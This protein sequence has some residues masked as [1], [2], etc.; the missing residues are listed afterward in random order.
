MAEGAGAAPVPG[1][2]VSSPGAVALNVSLLH[3]GARLVRSLADDL[4]TATTSLLPG[5]T[6]GKH[7]RH[8]ADFYEAF[9]EGAA[10]GRIDYENRRREVEL[11]TSPEAMAARLDALADALE[12]GAGALPRAVR[13][14]GE[15]APPD[16]PEAEWPESTLE[17]ELYVLVSHTIHHYALVAVLLRTLGVDPG[18]EFGVAPSTLRHWEAA[19]A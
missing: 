2:S 7:F 1:R 4:Y 13:V 18:P 3:G 9:L 11:E 19:K 5:G 15:G 16:V 6:V 12:R 17:R 8:C 10:A 14:R